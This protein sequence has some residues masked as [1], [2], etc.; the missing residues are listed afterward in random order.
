M[1]EVELTQELVRIN[2][3]NPPGNEMGVAKYIRDFLE[4]LKIDAEIIEFEK[5][6]CN[7][8]ASIGKGRGLMLNGHMDTVP[9]GDLSMWKN[10]PFGG[11]ISNGKI[12][13]RGTSD[14]K[15]GIASIL[16]AAER[17]SK[18]DFK[19]KLLLTFVAD[20]EVSLG[21][22]Q[23]LI[24]NRK[25]IF[26]DVKYGVVAECN[27][28]ELTIAQKG[29]VELKLRFAGKSAHGSRPD[30]GDNAIYKAADFIQ[31]IRK[32]IVQLE[33]KRSPMLGSGTINIGTIRGGSKINMVPDYCDVEVDRRTIPGET[34]AIAIRQIRKILK[35]LNLKADIEIGK[36]C[37]LP[38]QFSRNLEIV[39]LIRSL[40]KAKLTGSTGYDEA[41][42]YYRDANVPCVTYG[43]GVSDQAHVTDEYV[44]IKNL[45]VATNVY[46]KIIRK[47]CL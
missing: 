1:N 37:R 7:V 36:A 32:L 31:E 38:M 17:V 28:L 23:Y 13:G 40:T 10:D 22:S 42:M 5:N 18:E 21:G 33:K 35:K 12:Y 30:L 45:K 20:E 14:M 9:V 11:R 15:G 4:G 26:K 43:P 25:D 3:E 41:E 19:G 29:I 8:V 6:R 27:D 47:I 2:S 34:P 39:R 46:E 16:A 44:P 24:K